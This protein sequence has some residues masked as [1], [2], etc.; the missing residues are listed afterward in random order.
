MANLVYRVS[1]RTG[2][3]KKPC[4]EKNKTT[5]KESGHFSKTEFLMYLNL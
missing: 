2:Y 4:F 1:S 3:T 5:K